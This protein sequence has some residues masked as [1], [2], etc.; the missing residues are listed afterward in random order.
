[1]SD[2]QRIKHLQHLKFMQE[3][4]RQQVAER[5]EMLDAIVDR[6]QLEIDNLEAAIAAEPPS[7]TVLRSVS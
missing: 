7:A 3:L 5:K 4:R 2:D 1:M 6:C